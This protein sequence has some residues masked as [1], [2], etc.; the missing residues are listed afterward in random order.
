M[1]P[2]NFQNFYRF[3]NFKGFFM[4]LKVIPWSCGARRRASRT[5]YSSESWILEVNPEPAGERGNDCFVVGWK[6]DSNNLKHG[7]WCMVSNWDIPTPTSLSLEFLRLLHHVNLNIPGSCTSIH[8]NHY[9]VK[10]IWTF[11][12]TDTT[13]LCPVTNYQS[14]SGPFA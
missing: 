2:P 5:W 1:G 10:N 6:F 12:T 9:T 14:E 11:T 3:H 8:S 13:K 7:V 4:I